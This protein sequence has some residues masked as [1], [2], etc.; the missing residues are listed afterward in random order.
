MQNPHTLAANHEGTVVST[1]NV[2]SEGCEA[3]AFGVL[4]VY[5]ADAFAVNFSSRAAVQTGLSSR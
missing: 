4:K 2:G 1:K 5:M 3:R